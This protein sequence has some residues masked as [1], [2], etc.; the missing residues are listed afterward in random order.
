VDDFE[1]ELKVGF[2]D[3]ASQALS[4]VEQCFLSLESDPS[5]ED[6]L[7]RIFRLAHNLK[8][9][10]KAVGF[11]EMGEFTH[12]FETF[13]LKIKNKQLVCTP[14]V[15]SFLL[16]C[17]DH[18]V[19]M[20]N[21]LKDNL[22]AKF[23]STGLMQEMETLT[24][25]DGGG[26]AAAAGE[27]EA[28][29]AVET[30]PVVEEVP[31]P[32]A[33]AVPAPGSEHPSIEE[34]LAAAEVEEAAVAQAAAQVVTPAPEVAAAPVP[35]APVAAAPVPTPTLAAVAPTTAPEVSPKSA[36]PAAA[37]ANAPA[38]SAAAPKVEDSIRIQL[39]KVDQLINTVGE[40]VILQSVLSQQVS[41]LNSHTVKKTVMQLS[42]ISKEIQDVSMSLRL[43]PIKSLFQKMQR[44]VRDTAQALG[45]DVQLTLIGEETE[46]DKTV[47][48]KISDPLVH[49]IRN[50]V[51]HGIESKEVRK[52]NNKNEK[53]QV[54]LMAYHQAGRLVIEIKDD[55]GGLDPQK[56]MKIAQAKGLLKPGTQLTDAQA[57]NL[58]FAPGFSTKEKVTDVS[59][60]G[61]GMDVV[62]TN[63]L[64]L[65]G[66]IDIQSKVG[67]G[68]TFKIILPLTLSIIDGLVVTSTTHRYVIPLNHIHETLKPRKEQVQVSTGL[69][70]ILLLRGENLPLYRLSDFF[71]QKS[72]VPT[73]EMIALVIRTGSTPWAV[74][75]DDILAQAQIVTKQLGPELKSF[76]GVSGSTIL[77]D[78][79]PALILEPQ[80]LLKRK[81]TRSVIAPTSP[82]AN[83]TSAN[84]DQTQRRSV[85]S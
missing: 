17:N 83:T 68:T 49:L 78:G 61:V 73:S 4:E 27:V 33:E 45:K 77:G 32:V 63:V 6:N 72:T 60:R 14:N 79:R 54:T 62:K 2:L 47:I 28:A 19:L 21:G 70:E 74:L 84:V 7:N 37:Q 31:A 9:S 16:R 51:D 25:G 39:S 23:N 50:S 18:V 10:S 85:A 56:L 58:I 52:Q 76:V 71:S 53:G 64:E 59:G 40:I 1:R 26:A 36:A 11:D 29:P 42:K 81:I 12:H 13:I 57:Y 43:I 69:G 22:E 38:S 3:E 24:A 35:V 30:E 82:V 15:V 55:G 44:I 65:S 75:V 5:N 48:E 34:I 20:V 41:E 80:E 67:T 66:E 46:L 8:G